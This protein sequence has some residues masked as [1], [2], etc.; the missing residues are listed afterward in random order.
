MSSGLFEFSG[1]AARSDL[2]DHCCGEIFYRLEEEQARFLTHESEFRSKD[3]KWPRD[4]LHAW[5]RVWEYPYVF[6]HVR[7]IQSSRI[8]EKLQVLDFGSG[9]TFFPFSIAGLSCEVTCADIDPVVG[10]DI[11][12]AANFVRSDLGSVNVALIK[13][14][15][16]LVESESQDIVYCIS[17]LEHIPNF[18]TVI[19]EMHRILKS[20][21]QLILT[22]D[23]DLRGNYELGVNEFK[24]LLLKLDNL[25]T[26]KFEERQLHPSDLLTTVNSP[27]GMKKW[28]YL[29]AV[30]RFIKGLLRGK[31]VMVGPLDSLYLAVH[32]GVF[33]KK[34][35]AGAP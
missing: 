30:E 12:L 2:D 26:R 15:S 33:I 22:V 11:P 31:L 17:V 5:S 28:S 16:V 35:V 34:E 9:V 20:N 18:E 29:F 10:V 14:E 27:C 32:S 4:P 1:F 7:Q 23:I 21:G 13:N 25:F 3:Y 8:G 6:Y 24:R 19:D